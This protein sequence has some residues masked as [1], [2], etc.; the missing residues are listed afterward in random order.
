MLLGLFSWPGHSDFVAG[1]PRA[2][3]TQCPLWLGARKLGRSFW[4]HGF[5][6]DK[7]M[8]VAPTAARIRVI[9]HAASPSSNV[10]SWSNFWISTAVHMYSEASTTM[11]KPKYFSTGSAEISPLILSEKELKWKHL[12]IKV[13]VSPIQLLPHGFVK[14]PER[15]FATATR[16]GCSGPAKGSGADE[17]KEVENEN[18]MKSARDP[19][20]L[21]LDLVKSI[22][23]QENRLIDLWIPLMAPGCSRAFLPSK[24]YVEDE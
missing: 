24:D 22:G 4:V 17:N 5:L 11:L 13:L 2:G 16:T 23:L 6:G 10:Q 15:I 21:F 3:H 8:H 9:P 20:T 1:R 12:E 18:L 7:N 19:R 14:T